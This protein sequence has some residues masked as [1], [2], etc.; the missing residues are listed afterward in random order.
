M[1]RRGR[2]CDVGAGAG[3]AA[4]YFRLVYPQASLVCLEPDPRAYR[5]LARNAAT[6]G[7]CLP[8]RVALTLGVETHPFFIARNGDAALMIDAERFLADLNRDN[9]DLIRLDAGAAALPIL[10][11]LKNRLARTAMVL[12]ECEDRTDR[13]VIEALLDET[14]APRHGGDTAGGQR[15]AVLRPALRAG[16]QP[17]PILNSR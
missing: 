15:H 14:H 1:R 12:V 3:L 2:S 11:S 7:D 6:I 5:L 4:A 13:R 10:L 16:G 8:V 17:G 9:I